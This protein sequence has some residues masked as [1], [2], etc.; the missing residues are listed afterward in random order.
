MSCMN[1]TIDHQRLIIWPSLAFCLFSRCLY[2][3]RHQSCCCSWLYLCWRSSSIWSRFQRKD[4]ALCLVLFTL[5]AVLQLDES[6]SLS[7]LCSVGP[8]SSG[9]P[10][11]SC[12][13]LTTPLPR[14]QMLQV[15][16][17]QHHRWQRP[18]STRLST[19]RS[20]ASCF[21][22]GKGTHRTWLSAIAR[23]G[24]DCGHRG[25]ALLL[26]THRI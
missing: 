18:T 6:S 25:V 9:G 7:L 12:G 4:G 23:S 24:G 21:E 20:P 15:P 3:H 16:S 1:V 22:A 8:G 19:D 17:K 11:D 10:C 5:S 14:R 2:K 13:A 26:W